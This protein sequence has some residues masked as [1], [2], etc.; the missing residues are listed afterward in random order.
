MQDWGTLLKNAAEDHLKR[1]HNICHII[2]GT[3]FKGSK[4]FPH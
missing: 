2:P 1:C 4:V 3:T